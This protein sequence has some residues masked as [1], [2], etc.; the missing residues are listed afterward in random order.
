M[1]DDDLLEL[2]IRV[3]RALIG[4]ATGSM[5]D[6]KSISKYEA[7]LAGNYVLAILLE[8]QPAESEK[9]GTAG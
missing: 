9:G 6:L 8:R 3:M 1:S 7:A 5:P 2:A 4:E